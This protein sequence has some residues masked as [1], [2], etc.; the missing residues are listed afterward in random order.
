MIPAWKAGGSSGTKL[1]PV[2]D[3]ETLLIITHTLI[4]F[5]TVY[6]NVIYLELPMKNIQKL[7]L[8]QNVAGQAL[9]CASRSGCYTSKA[10]C[11]LPVCLW[12]QLKVDLTF[13]DLHGMEPDY[14]RDYL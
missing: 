7:Q 11:M 14:L 10:K 5:Q 8:M 2:L 6:Y 13:K 3:L 9:M 4:T 1:C 12:I